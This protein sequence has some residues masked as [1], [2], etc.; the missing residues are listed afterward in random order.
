MTEPG[1]TTSPSAT[2]TTT[3]SLTDT[4]SSNPVEL[5]PRP[6]P[7]RARTP[8]LYELDVVRILTFACVIAVHTISYTATSTDVVL[9]GL[10]A[11]VHFTR[12]V[13]FALSSFVL[14]YSYL[15]R[16]VPMRKFWP[17]RFLLVGVPYLVWSAIYVVVPYLHAP[18]GTLVSL[19]RHYVYAVVTGTAWFHLY[20][21]LVTMQV[22]LLLPVIMWVVRKARGHHVTLLVISGAAQLLLTAAY[23]YWPAATALIN[24]Y[25]DQLFISYQFFILLGAVAADH[26]VQLMAWVRTHRRP[27][28]VVTVL[29][30]A[31]TI[32]VYVLAVRS[33]KSPIA[34]GVPLQPIIMV[35]SVA[36]AL[37]LLALGSLWSDHRRP[38]G[39]LARV[40]TLGSDRSFGIF[41]SH[42]LVLWTVLLLGNHWLSTNIAKP[43]LTLV[44]Y[45]LVVLGAIAVTELARRTPLSLPLAGRPFRSNSKAKAKAKA[46]PH[47]NESKTM[48]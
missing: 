27:I 42:P 8:H 2:I 22:Y 41:L 3:T 40:V 46:S 14:V 45:I 32:A 31:V 38:G 39:F 44:T 1:E 29:T 4:A 24:P 11:L 37:G 25:N 15:S 20:F 12:E 34:A 47:G 23:M 43:W 48:A 28:G 35:W 5:A 10:L 16:P 26:S 7:A 6:E 19:F 9:N 21:L 36:I 18:Q 17:R 13:F 30:A 33:G